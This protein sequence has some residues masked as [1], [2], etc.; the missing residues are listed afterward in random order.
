ME[1]GGYREAAPSIGA[2]SRGALSLQEVKLG[3]H[4]VFPLLEA[5]NK[6][7]PTSLGYLLIC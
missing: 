1:S 7:A 3:S 6:T 4:Y 2:Q 5:Q